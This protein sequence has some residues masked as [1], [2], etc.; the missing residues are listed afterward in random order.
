MLLPPPPLAA[1]SSATCAR[2]LPVRSEPLRPPPAAAGWAGL[3]WLGGEAEG[4]GPGSWQGAGGHLAVPAA[5]G[6]LLFPPSWFASG[7]GESPGGLIARADFGVRS[8]AP[9]SVRSS[10]AWLNRGEAA[11]SQARRR[12]RGSEEAAS[13]REHQRRGE[14]GREVAR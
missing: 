11:F 9:P 1:S 2:R 12:C 8:Q 5:K 13:R 6:T 14:D 3:G 10:L 4:S 7:S